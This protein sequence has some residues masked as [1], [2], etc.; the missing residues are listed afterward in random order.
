MLVLLVGVSTGGEF[1]TLRTLGDT[2]SLHVYQIIND[3]RDAVKKMKAQ[4]LQAMFTI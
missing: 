4:T 1:H 2:R 3:A